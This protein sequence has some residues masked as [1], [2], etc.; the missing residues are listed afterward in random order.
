MLLS[1]VVFIAETCAR[2]SAQSLRVN[3]YG[4]LTSTVVLFWGQLMKVISSTKCDVFTASTHVLKVSIKYSFS[5]THTSVA[6]LYEY[7]TYK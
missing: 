7:I 4:L 6:R 2:M 5:I 3:V 1:C